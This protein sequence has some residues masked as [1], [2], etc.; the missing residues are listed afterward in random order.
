[1]LYKPINTAMNLLFSRRTT[2]TALCSAGTRREVK[3]SVLASP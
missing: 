3:P 2:Y 1:M